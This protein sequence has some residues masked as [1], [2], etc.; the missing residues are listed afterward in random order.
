ML[1]SAQVQKK[2]VKTQWSISNLLKISILCYDLTNL[3][4][5]RQIKACHYI[6]RPGLPQQPQD[7]QTQ[8][9]VA[10]ASNADVLAELISFD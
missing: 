4:K 10:P 6:I 1:L 2:I 7:Q 9:P 3:I 8:R 5:I